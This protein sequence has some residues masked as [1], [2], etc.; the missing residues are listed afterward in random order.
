MDARSVN[1]DLLG[2]F[3]CSYG[4]T[5]VTLPL[6]ARR[7]LALLALC[8][9]GTHRGGAAERLWPDSPAN[10]AAGNL[11]SAL[12]RGR[13]VAQTTLIECV[14]PRLRMSPSVAIDLHEVQHR[15]QRA[16][17]DPAQV[18]TR[19]CEHLVAEL[20]RPL[21][22]EWSEDWLV[23]E[24][25]HWDQVRLHA[26]EGLAEA[27]LVRREYMAAMRTA[28]AAIA[29]EPVREKAHRTVVQV[30]LAE[31]NAGSALVHYQ[32]YRALLRR[33]LGVKPSGQL[34]RL[35]GALAPERI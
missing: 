28:L 26:L 17:R 30:H 5:A 31:G 25:L 7:L 24:Q 29:V 12:W 35:V 19:E 27:L 1:I 2:G 21:L 22:P 11:R 14:G 18:S 33:E 9:S 23:L 3:E 13:R 10:R 8:G 20:S 34:T 16:M 32:Q 6:G 15:A 4:E